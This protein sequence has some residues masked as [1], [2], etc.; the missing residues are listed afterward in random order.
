[1]LQATKKNTH[2]MTKSWLKR[3]NLKRKTESLFL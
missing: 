2:K 1:M 3:G